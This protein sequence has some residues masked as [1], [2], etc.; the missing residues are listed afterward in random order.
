MKS[1]VTTPLAGISRR[2]AYAIAAMLLSILGLPAT[3]AWAQYSPFIQEALPVS[4]QAG[5]SAFVLTVKGTGFSSYAVVY[6]QTG[7]TNT[8]LPTTFV[9]DGELTAQVPAS[10]ILAQQT[11]Q[12][13][14]K[15]PVSY[16]QTSTSNALPFPV[17]LPSGVPSFTTLTMGGAVSSDAQSE[18][19]GDFNGDGKQDLIVNTNQTLDVFL[20]NGNGS[21]I[22]TYSLPVGGSTSSMATG[23]FNGDGKLDLVAVGG[24]TI[25]VFLGHGDGTFITMPPMI[26][27]ASGTNLTS[28]KVADVNGAGYPD[29]LIT[30]NEG[31]NLEALSVFF[32]LSNGT[33]ALGYT[34]QVDLPS[35]SF[36]ALAIGDFNGDGM[37]DAA[38]LCQPTAAVD[39][40]VLVLLGNGEGDFT[41]KDSFTTQPSLSL[42]AADFN[43]DGKRTADQPLP[44]QR[45]WHVYQ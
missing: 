11:A 31:G 16:G 22:K 14:V 26:F 24:N 2:V 5:G 36:A 39:P 8:S 7:A 15:V 23:D 12:V 33:F 20:G 44:G 40:E 38:I 37:V 30:Q 6:W 9:S 21:F 27:G 34:W 45:R 13:T 4:A 29:L 32:G 43:N 25:N 35:Y 10:L 1:N 19:T 42:A 41:F 17:T 28:V 3:T 18:I